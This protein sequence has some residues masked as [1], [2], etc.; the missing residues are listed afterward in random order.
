[1]FSAP[2]FGILAITVYGAPG[3]TLA[4]MQHRVAMGESLVESGTR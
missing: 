2:R 4:E 3:L 1:M